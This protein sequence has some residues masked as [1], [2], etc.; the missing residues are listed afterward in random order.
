[1]AECKWHCG[2]PQKAPD[3]LIVNPGITAQ[4]STAKPLP[5]AKKKQWAGLGQRTFP[6]HWL[7]L[8]GKECNARQLS[9]VF[10][11]S[12]HCSNETRL[13]QCLV[14]WETLPLYCRYNKSGLRPRNELSFAI[15]S[16][17]LPSYW[18]SIVLA[19]Y[20]HHTLAAKAQC[21]QQ[22][23]ALTFR[24]ERHALCGSLREHCWF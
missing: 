1:M 11:W 13:Y 15:I 12:V 19:L 20:T 23:T 22:E 18:K 5:W 6:G 10:G 8:S 2:S 16:E 21:S 14:C 3:Q 4:R 24:T 9:P 7:L 17:E